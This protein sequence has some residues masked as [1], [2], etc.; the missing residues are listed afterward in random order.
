MDTKVTHTHAPDAEQTPIDR[1]LATVAD[2]LTTLPD[3]EHEQV[4]M[5]AVV[6]VS[7][8]DDI[9]P[10]EAIEWA[11]YGSGGDATESAWDEAGRLLNNARVEDE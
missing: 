5:T 7:Q 3:L 1:L 8:H 10:D 4:I 11:R 6:L 2:A 9:T